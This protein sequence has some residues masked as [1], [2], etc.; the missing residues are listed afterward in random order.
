MVV[1][2]VL[3]WDTPEY[4]GNLLH[5]L[6]EECPV[7]ET[8]HKIVVL[9]QGSGWRTRRVLKRHQERISI[10]RVRKNIGFPAGHNLVFNTARETGAFDAFCVVNS[11]VRFL[12]A[13]WLDQLSTSLEEN[14]NIALTGPVALRVTRSGGRIGHGEPVTDEDLRRGQ[15]EFLSGCASLIRADVA[16][17]LGLYD[18]VFTPGYFEDADMCFR[19]VAAGHGIVHCPIRIEHGY[20]GARTSTA[21]VKK[22]SLRRK[23]GNFRERNR[24]EF[25]KRWPLSPAEGETPRT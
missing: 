18:E 20:L 3:V 2:S 23:Y 22:D 13:N 19:Y 15:F 1:L 9:D 6:L 7:G 14:P 17:R 5:N 8:P 24:Q 11:D 16:I 21:K 12:E 10:I 4:A 25:L